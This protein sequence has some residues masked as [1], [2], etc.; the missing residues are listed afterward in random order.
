VRIA[1]SGLPGLQVVGVD[2]PVALAANGA[3]MLPL[4]LQAGSTGLATGSHPVEIVVIAED[5]TT[6]R[7]RSTFIIPR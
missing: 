6:R 2:Q 3:R 4:R 5:G 1:A 7:E